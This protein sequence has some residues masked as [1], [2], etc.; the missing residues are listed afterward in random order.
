MSTEE[1]PGHTIEARLIGKWHRR[2]NV[3]EV[4]ALDENGY[5][6]WDSH[7]VRTYIYIRNTGD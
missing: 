5:A 7:E 6:E 2:R 4:V 1:R 3:P